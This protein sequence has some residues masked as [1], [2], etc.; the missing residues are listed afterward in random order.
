[1]R[2]AN[3]LIT[4]RPGCGK[5][6]FLMDLVKEI[7]VP[8]TGFLTREV[9][10]G[11]RR[12]GF[13][14]VTLDGREGWL[15]HRSFKGP[16]RVGSYGVSLE[17]LEQIGIKALTAEEPYELV[18]VDEIGKMECLSPLF[19]RVLIQILEGERPLLGT[20]ALKGPRFIQ[21]IK[22]RDDILVISLESSQKESLRERILKM[23]GL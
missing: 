19:R 17:A 1:M 21:E 23:L 10:E 9:R 7:N 20:I 14:L 4:G 18:V 11:G 16:H 3:I 22:E 6:T 5:T 13:K 15:A 2:K 12:V 8:A